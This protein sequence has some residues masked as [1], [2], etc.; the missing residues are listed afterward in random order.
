MLLRICFD[1]AMVYFGN[2]MQFVIF[3]TKTCKTH[4]TFLFLPL[5]LATARFDAA[6]R[7]F[8]FSF[9]V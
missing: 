6:F 3:I 8:Q 2:N 1:L 7:R 5:N 4:K 9:W